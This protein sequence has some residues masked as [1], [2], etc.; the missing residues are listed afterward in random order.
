MR[1]TFET[2]A[3]SCSDPRLRFQSCKSLGPTSSRTSLPFPPRRRECGRPGRTARRLSPNKCWLTFPVY[4]IDLVS[5]YHGP[6]ALRSASSWPHGS[7]C[8][9]RNSCRRRLFGG[10]RRLRRGTRGAIP[11]WALEVAGWNAQPDAKWWLPLITKCGGLTGARPQLH[12]VRARARNEP[13]AERH[14]VV[15][16]GGSP[17]RLCRRAQAN[18]R[19]GSTR[20]A[21]RGHFW[22][23]RR[24]A[25]T[26]WTMCSCR[27]WREAPCASPIRSPDTRGCAASRRARRWWK[28]RGG[29]E[30]VIESPTEKGEIFVL[31][32]V[33]RPLETIPAEVLTGA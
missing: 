2:R 12:P 19:R 1:V 16:S 26:R 25:A 20:C 4:P 13:R 9:K 15:R 22:S 28:A 10:Y 24:S 23:A 6:E 18:S 33:S 11:E 30:Q 17:A 29:W 7:T 8:E 14:D 3:T 31:E 5:I 27:A 32:L 21:P